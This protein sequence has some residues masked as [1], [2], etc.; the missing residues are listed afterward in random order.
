MRDPRA[1]MTVMPVALGAALVL[2]GLKFYA[3]WI[4]GSSAL[5]SDALESIINVVAAGFS[6][7][8]V[9]LAAKPP[10]TTHPYG[11]GKI[12]FFAAG[13]EGALIVLA[14]LAMFTKGVEHVLSPHGLPHLET[15]L[16]ILIV[17]GLVNLGLATVLVRTGKRTRSIVVEAHGRHVFTDVWSSAAVVVGLG[18][19]HVTGWNQLD[20]GVACAVGVSVLFMAVAVVRRAFRGLMDESDPDLLQ[21]IGVL[22]QQHRK[23]LWIDAHRLRAWKS[24]QRIHVDFHLILPRD[25]PLEQGHGEMKEL[26]RI[27][28]EH[29]GGQ[30]EILIH[31]DPCEDPECPI[32]GNDPCDLRTEQTSQTGTWNW[33]ELTSDTPRTETDS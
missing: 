1:G 17:T 29:F 8:S 33:R 11:H 26:E 12:E 31:L 21:E 22:L 32:C 7:F 5:L 10:D 28:G 15:G 30:A 20:G 13:F 24:G 25:L 6:L 18:V 14:A 2:T 3:Y 9:V 16:A 23:D 27:F 19:V 4:T